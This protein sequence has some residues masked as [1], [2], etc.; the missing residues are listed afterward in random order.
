MINENL[1]WK[2]HVKLVKNKI[3]KSLGIHPY[4]NYVNI[5]LAGNN[6][7]HLILF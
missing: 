5:V 3:G 6:K 1:T 2:T 7:M 4:I